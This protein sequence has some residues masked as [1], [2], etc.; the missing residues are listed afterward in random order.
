MNQP[1]EKLVQLHY[2][3]GNPADRP[4]FKAETGMRSQMVSQCG[5][6]SEGQEL[7]EQLSDWI[8]SVTKSHQLPGGMEWMV[9]NE[10][11]DLFW[12]AASIR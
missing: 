9:V 5:F 12:L 4:A 10:D 1:S 11:S 2:W 8:E 7:S 3:P 6:I